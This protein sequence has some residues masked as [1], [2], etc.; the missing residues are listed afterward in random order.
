MN[1]III[2][3]RQISVT[4][5]NISVINDKVIVDGV[6]VEEGLSGHVEI[7]FVGD[8]ATLKTNGSAT[9]EG[10][11]MGNVDAGGSVNCGDVKGSVDA[12]VQ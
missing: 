2:N 4:G 11:V 10:N 1:T 9:I 8:L 5:R 7:S 6:I 3:G 12:G